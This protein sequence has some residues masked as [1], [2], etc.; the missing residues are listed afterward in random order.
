MSSKEEGTVIEKEDNVCR[1]F[2]RN[3][4][5]RGERFVMKILSNLGLLNSLFTDANIHTLQ[6][7][8]LRPLKELQNYTCKT[9]WNSVMTFKMEGVTEPVANL[10][11]A[12]VR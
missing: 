9:K 12:A 10:F 7:Q 4:C 3:V 11:I 6:T 1:D 2:L 8:P 5:R